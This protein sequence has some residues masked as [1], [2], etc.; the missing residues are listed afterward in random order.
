MDKKTKDLLGKFNIEGEPISITPYGEGHINQTFLVETDK[1]R[2]LLQRINPF[3]MPNVEGLMENICRVTE[4]LKKKGTETLS[5]IFTKDGKSFYK[6]EGYYRV[7]DFI[8]NTVTY[9]RITDERVF[10]NIGRAFGT[11]QNQ[12]ADFNAG[13]LVEVIP[14]FHNTPDRFCKFEQAVKND[15][16]NRAAT[17]SEEIEFFKERKNTLG[18]IVEGLAD[19]SIPLRVTHNDTKVNNILMDAVTNDARAIVDLDTVMPGS[20]TY[21]FG[22]AVRSGANTAK[23]DERDLSKITINLGLFKAYAKGFCGAVKQSITK[24]EKDLLAYSVYLMTIEVAIRFLTDYLMGD[25][26]FRTKYENHNLI[27]AKAQIQYVK[28]IEKNMAEMEK[29]IREL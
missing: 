4:H 22:D 26:Y 12:L 9:Q 11:F 7:Y 15:V 21:D 8:E 3:V 23:E 24:K 28:E 25:V 27:R 1:K 5:V 2:Y 14:N 29:I 19:G 18:K 16:K 20:M 10:E 17:C 13:L 6:G